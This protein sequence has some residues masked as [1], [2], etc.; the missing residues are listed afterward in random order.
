MRIPKV[1]VCILLPLL[2]FSQNFSL[3]GIIKSNNQNDFIVGNVYLLN[4]DSMVAKSA[5]VDY[6]SLA[7]EE[8]L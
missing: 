7:I 3:S 4:Q 2:G 5:I 1:I 6:K 8:N